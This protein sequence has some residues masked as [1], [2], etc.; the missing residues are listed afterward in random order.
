MIIKGWEF[1]E[2]INGEWKPSG[3][4]VAFSGYLRLIMNCT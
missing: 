2:D 4:K 1:M 3:L